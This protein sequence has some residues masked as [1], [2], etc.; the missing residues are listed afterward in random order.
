[1]GNHFGRPESN[2]IGLAGEYRVVSELLLRGHNPAKRLAPFGEDLILE[3]GLRIEIKAGRLYPKD[4]AY[5]FDLTYG[6]GNQKDNQDHYDYLVCW[7]LDD[8]VFFV[9]P[10]EVITA[11]STVSITLAEKSKYAPYREAWDL[12]QE[13]K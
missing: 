1:M 7:C 10:V 5:K 3:N 9:I 6:H 13:R 2:F 4:N 11:Q 8:N 12:L